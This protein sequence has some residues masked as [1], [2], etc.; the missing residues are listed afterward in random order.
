MREQYKKPEN[1]GLK[2]REKEADERRQ[3]C[4][5]ARDSA[6]KAGR[7]LCT[8]CGFTGMVIAFHGKKVE[9]E[10][11]ESRPSYAFRCNHCAAAEQLGLSED[12]P[13]WRDE[14]RSDFEVSWFGPPV[15]FMA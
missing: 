9:N 3:R 7:C 15:Q 10:I 12:F 13:G 1:D 2:Q 14:L 8:Y 4:K 5:R 11:M 6:A